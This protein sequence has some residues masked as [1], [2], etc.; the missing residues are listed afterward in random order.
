MPES[1]Q[2]CTW[3][4]SLLQSSVHTKYNIELFLPSG[5]TWRQEITYLVCNDADTS[6]ANQSFLYDRFPFIEATLSPTGPDGQNVPQFDYVL[7]M[8]S[9]RLSKTHLPLRFFECSLRQSGAKVLVPIPNLKDLLVSHFH[10]GKLLPEPATFHGTWNEYFQDLFVKKQLLYE[11]NFHFYEAWW[12]YKTENPSQVLF[13][14]Y[15]DLH[16]DRPRAIRTVANFLG[17]SMTE[18]QVQ[19]IKE[20]TTFESMKKNESLCPAPFAPRKMFFWKGEVGD[21]KNYFSQ[22]QSDYVDTLVRE[23]LTPLCLDVLYH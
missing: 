3:Q 16:R 4:V 8:T 9:P 14:W 15:E 20:H 6:K 18:E 5:T 10:F 2:Y 23:R 7:S 17:K 19:T 12:R 21:W 11:D 13:V 22:A 1:K